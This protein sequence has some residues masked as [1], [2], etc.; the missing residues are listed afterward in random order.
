MT[1]IFVPVEP[2]QSAYAHSSSTSDMGDIPRERST[3]RRSSPT[4]W[5]PG[6]DPV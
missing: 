1:K 6:K 5:T 3:M 2:P 4:L